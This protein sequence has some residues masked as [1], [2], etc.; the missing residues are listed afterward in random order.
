[1]MNLY[2]KRGYVACC[3]ILLFCVSCGDMDLFD[4]DKW[5]DKI[6]GWQ[7]GIAAPGVH[8]KFTMW[9]L[10]NQGDSLNANIQQGADGILF[11]QYT[12][13]DIYTVELSDVFELSGTPVSFIKSLDLPDDLTNVIAGNPIPDNIL[14]KDSIK[15][16]IPLPADFAG[17]ELT[18]LILETGNCVYTLPQLSDP[19]AAQEVVYDVKVSYLSGG[20][21]VSLLN[22][23]NI[24]SATDV[25]IPLAGKKFDLVKDGV[26]ANNIQLKF[27]IE[28]KAGGIYNGSDFTVAIEFRDYDFEKIEGKIVKNGG[29][30]I[31]EDSFDMDI[32]F[33]NEIG[34]SFTFT[35]PQIALRL[36]NNGVGIPVA[37]DMEFAG[38]DRDGRKDTLKLEAPL[39]FQGNPVLGTPQVIEQIVNTS[40]S[41]VAA[42]LS[43]PPQGDVKYYGS[44]DL[45]PDGN[46]NN[47]LYKHGSLGIDAYVKVPLELS[48]TA[49]GLSYKDTISDIDVDS[50]IADKVLEARIVIAVKENSLPLD[51]KI[52]ELILLDENNREIERVGAEKGKTNLIKASTAGEL[53]FVMDKEKAKKL[54][55]MEHILLD[56]NVMTPEGRSVAVKGDASISLVVRIEVRADITDTNF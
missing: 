47:V 36:K 52:S 33:L 22:E 41:N 14:I 24:S 30:E 49:Q 32:D 54:S 4:S 1:M 50:D 10:I 37:L 56:I 16:A 27:D 46:V 8:G 53:A 17:S 38:Q 6:E 23:Q 28:L 20:T 45:N 34:G 12:K 26:E 5:S 18:S 25:T 7:P 42:F 19:G 3:A 21:W 31:A 51:L 11:I 48:T 40:N 13:K 43:L 29:I 44:V 55:Q 9:E 35:N 39:K 15:Q 2:L